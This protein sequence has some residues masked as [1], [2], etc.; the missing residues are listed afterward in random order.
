LWELISTRYI[1]TYP[2]PKLHIHKHNSSTSYQD[3]EPVSKLRS[4]GAAQQTRSNKH[5]GC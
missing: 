5:R 4:R 2:C 1:A 3:G